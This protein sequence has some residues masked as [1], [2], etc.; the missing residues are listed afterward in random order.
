M[1]VMMNDICYFKDVCHNLVSKSI[2]SPER[3]RS[4]QRKN[5]SDSLYT[6]KHTEGRENLSSEKQELLNL[7]KSP[8]NSVCSD[9]GASC[10]C[11]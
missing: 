9:C 7:L 1:E 4:L 8:E 2:G 10:K 3:I 6:P 11:S 5:S